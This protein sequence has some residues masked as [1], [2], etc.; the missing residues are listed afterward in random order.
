[1]LSVKYRL[2]ACS[3]VVE[4][5]N[6]PKKICEEFLLHEDASV[7]VVNSKSNKKD[8]T[9]GK[10]T[11]WMGKTFNENA[12]VPAV[13]VETALAK[14]LVS[15][16]MFGLVMITPVKA[17]S[18]ENAFITPLLSLEARER[19][20]EIW[21]LDA[22]HSAHL[23]CTCTSA[24]F[25]Q[26]GDISEEIVMV[27]VFLKLIDIDVLTSRIVSR[28]KVGRPRSQSTWS[29]KGG[30]ATTR[31]EEWYLNDI[32][33]N[34]P[35]KYY[36]WQVIVVRNGTNRVGVVRAFKVVKHVRLW[37]IGFPDFVE[38]GAVDLTAMELAQAL[39]DG[40][41]F[42]VLGPAE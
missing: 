36:K 4:L 25:M 5:P 17:A 10:A 12:R 28:K 41:N 29:D 40:A 18:E 26:S 19:I 9:L 2:L 35:G 22:E 6:V 24:E 38:E 20:R 23:K 34:K 7:F 1:M 31:S 11:T 14:I 15:A 27:L 39:F 32:E 16:R 30:G 21:H 37:E 33:K 13:L 42:G 8:V 3:P